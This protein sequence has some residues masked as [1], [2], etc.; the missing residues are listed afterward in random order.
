[1][2]LDEV[3]MQPIQPPMVAVDASPCILMHL[4]PVQYVAKLCCDLGHAAC[5][6][7]LGFSANDC[8]SQAV[9]ISYEP[10]CKRT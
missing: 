6:A 9:T 8:L 1:M 3:S 4:V 5:T 2:F 10:G 7:Y